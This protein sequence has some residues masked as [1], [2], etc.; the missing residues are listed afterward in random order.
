MPC[1]EDD[2]GFESKLCGGNDCNDKDKKSYPGAVEICDGKDNDCDKM[3]DDGC[4]DLPSLRID[5]DGDGW[6]GPRDCDD[7][8]STIYPGAEEVCNGLDDDCDREIDEGLDCEESF[9]DMT[10]DVEELT[11][12]EILEVFELD[13][14]VENTGETTLKDLTISLELPKGK[15]WKYSGVAHVED[16]TPDA[17]DSHT[18]KVLIGP[19]DDTSATIRVD[20]KADGKRAISK[21]IPITVKIPTFAVKPEPT[22]NYY[23][24]KLRA[25]FY[26]L[27]F[28]YIVNNKDKKTDLKNLD[29]E[30]G[31]NS[32]GILLDS[33]VAAD[34][35]SS[36]LFEGSF[37][38][39]AGEI[40]VQE[41]PSNPYLVK[42]GK[43][44]VIEG[45]LRE[46]GNTKYTSEVELD[47]SG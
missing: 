28:Y 1:D 37:T 7:N 30:F 12:P 41:M 5:H 36:G 33:T 18:F 21:N 2:D 39:P 22:L 26:K 20:L 13:V 25:G 44:Y 19:H 31:V 46:E 11:E 14:G 47:L 42:S 4:V 10:L 45:R 43:V 6:Y 8:D 23:S 32:K 29:L 16:L 17:K 9:K 40:L 35:V 27:S 38:I 3:I 15:G 24:D 34:L